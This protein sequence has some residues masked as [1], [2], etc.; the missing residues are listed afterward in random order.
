MSPMHA[1]ASLLKCGNCTAAQLELNDLL[2]SLYNSRSVPLLR[3]T[4]NIVEQVD[5]R[6]NTPARPV[7]DGDLVS[8]LGLGAMARKPVGD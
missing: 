6:F 2:L 1:F 7:E 5:I 8:V 3:G 4:A